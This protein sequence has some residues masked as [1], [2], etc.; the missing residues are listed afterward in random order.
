MEPTPSPPHPPDV[1]WRE[2]PHAGPGELGV[3]VLADP[4]ALLDT[5]DDASFRASDERMPY[6]SLLWPAGESLASAV[7]AGCTVVLK[8]ASPTHTSRP[9]TSANV[10]VNTL[11]PTAPRPSQADHT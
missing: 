1:V 6:W 5:M 11:S 3:F 10:Y 9:S 8:P 4:D 7:A 2:I